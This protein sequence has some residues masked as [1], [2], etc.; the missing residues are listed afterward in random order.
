MRKKLDREQFQLDME[1]GFAKLRWEIGKDV[2]EQ[3]N[4]EGK[5]TENKLNRGEKTCEDTQVEMEENTARG[6]RMTPGR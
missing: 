6:E 2:E 4:T 5:K 1:C 3:E